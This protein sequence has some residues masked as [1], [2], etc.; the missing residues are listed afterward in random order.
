MQCFL[1]VSKD[2]IGVTFSLLLYLVLFSSVTR[3]Y[4]I[5]QLIVSQFYCSSEFPSAPHYCWLGY[6]N[7]KAQL[8]L[9]N[10]RDACEKFARFT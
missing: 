3:G 10:P 4:A 2:A 7:K 9:T 8:S 6:R 5:Q 1:S